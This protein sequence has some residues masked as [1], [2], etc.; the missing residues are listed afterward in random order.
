MEGQGLEET[1]IVMNIIHNHNRQVPPYVGLDMLTKIAV[2]VDY[3]DCLEAIEPCSD[4]WIE[5][6]KE[7]IPKDY[8]KA[9]IQWLCI[10]FVFD[11]P[12]ILQATIFTAIH[13]ATGPVETLDL[14]IPVAG[15]NSGPPLKVNRH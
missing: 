12:R 14:P 1:L 13:H 2:L 4:K 8:S 3:L 7:Y 11:K 10:S 6:L 15:E 9:L 5:Q